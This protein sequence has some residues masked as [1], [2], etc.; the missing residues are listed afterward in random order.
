MSR[1]LGHQFLRFCA[2]GGVGFVVDAGLLWLLLQV[3]ALGPY[4]GR[5]V[6]F[7][8]AATVTWRLHRVV[9][10][11][12]ARRDRPARQWVSFLT[13]NGLGAGLNYGIYAALVAT[14]GFFGRQPVAAVAVGSG[15]A[16][17]VNFL[18]NRH[19]VF[20]DALS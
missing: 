7:L 12:D 3:T 4:L 17:V 15:V 2:V 18:T 11:P 20:R 13:V 14:V 9:T 6:S 8:V 5:A 10:F 19:V 1:A 16:M